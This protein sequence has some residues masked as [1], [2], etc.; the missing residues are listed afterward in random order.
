MSIFRK[1]KQHTAE[2]V[3]VTNEALWSELQR[4]ERQ[5]GQAGKQTGP[6]V[7]HSLAH[8]A[9]SSGAGFSPS[10]SSGPQPFA[11]DSCSNTSEL[12]T[13][14][15]TGLLSREAHSQHMR[16]EPSPLKVG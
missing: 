7:T 15:L 12:Q 10:S 3:T 6:P 1:K 14:T 9:C 16:W 13:V 5:Y 8:H 4:E 11:K 2:M